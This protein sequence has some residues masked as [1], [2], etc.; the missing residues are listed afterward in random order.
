MP[1]P[2]IQKIEKSVSLP[3]PFKWHLRSIYCSYVLSQ[4]QH[5]QMCA[6]FNSRWILNFKKCTFLKILVKSSYVNSTCSSTSLNKPFEQT[7]VFWVKYYFCLVSGKVE[8]AKST[9]TGNRATEILSLVFFLLLW[10][11]ILL[12][13]LIK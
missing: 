1:N 10:Y 5:Q 3:C 13:Q 11:G 2:F 9:F 7:K 8:G 4:S 12:I 6:Q